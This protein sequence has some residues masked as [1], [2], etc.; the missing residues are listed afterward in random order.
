MTDWLKKIQAT[1]LGI[2]ILGTAAS[3]IQLANADVIKE[4]Q[5]KMKMVAKANKALKK[6][7]KAGDMAA[8]KKQGAIIVS[9]ANKLAEMFPK[10]SGYDTLG[11]KVPHSK[12]EIWMDWNTFLEKLDAMK[13]VAEKVANGDLTAAKSMGKTCGSCHRLFR[14]K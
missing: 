8:L 3:A 14:S 13:I 12:P 10:G 9:S 11:K 1:V 5:A 4:R 6:A 2:I 7:S